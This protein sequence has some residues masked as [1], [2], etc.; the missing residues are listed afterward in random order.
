MGYV[1]LPKQDRYE[2]HLLPSPYIHA[3]KLSIEL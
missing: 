3:Q 2:P 1:D